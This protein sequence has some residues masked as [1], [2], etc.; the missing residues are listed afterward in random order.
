MVGVDAPV[1]GRERSGASRAGALTLGWKADGGKAGGPDTPCNIVE[2]F[3]GCVPRRG[4]G[5][6]DGGTEDGGTATASGPGSCGTGAEVSA[7]GSGR[8]EERRVGKEWVSTCRSR[9]SQDH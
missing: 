3:C 9:W 2:H 1:A 7:S 6:E 5:T 8:S 4:G